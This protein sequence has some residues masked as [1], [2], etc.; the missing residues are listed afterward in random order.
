MNNKKLEK[1]K[2]PSGRHVG[3]IGG[4]R[5]IRIFSSNTVP[6]TLEFFFSSRVVMSKEY[7]AQKKRRRNRRW[8]IIGVDEEISLFSC[9][10]CAFL[11]IDA[12]EKQRRKKN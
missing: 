10:Y 9:F 6:T 2:Q 8:R 3:K 1:E 4:G 7:R 5:E 11:L 12:R